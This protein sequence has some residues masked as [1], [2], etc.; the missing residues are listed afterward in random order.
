MA[1]QKEINSTY[2]YMDEI[3]RL[4]FGEMADISGAMYN[5]NF[6]KTLQQAQKNKHKYIMDGLD[7]TKD[8]RVLDIGCG[9]GP[10]LNA[11]KERGDME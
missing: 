2:N 7:I 8:S 5:G 9:W 10:I 11:L 6:S 3:F 1:T 4:T